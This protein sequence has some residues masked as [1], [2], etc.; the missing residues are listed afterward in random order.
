MEENTRIGLVF[1][2]EWGT[3][4]NNSK[5]SRAIF[6]TFP[7]SQGHSRDRRSMREG[8]TAC[9]SPHSQEV[10]LD[11]PLPSLEMFRRSSRFPLTSISLDSI[12]D[13][14]NIHPSCSSVI[15]F[16]QRN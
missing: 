16:R 11:D 15:G 8:L 13:E 14:H 9:T 5:L 10:A 3:L 2:F 1:F 7:H 6:A 12:T 4:Q